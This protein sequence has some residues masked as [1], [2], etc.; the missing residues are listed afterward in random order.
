MQACW[1]TSRLTGKKAGRT[2]VRQAIKCAGQQA[3]RR[4]RMAG[5]QPGN[6]AGYQ[7]SGLEVHRAVR[8]PGWQESGQVSSLQASRL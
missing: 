2:V 7:A 4:N 1:Q 5:Q 3:G 6:L 8:A